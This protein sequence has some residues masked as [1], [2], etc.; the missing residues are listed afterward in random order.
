MELPIAL[1]R[2]G[3]LGAQVYR[4]LREAI[5]DGRLASGQALPATRALARRL[6]VSRNTVLGAYE[7]LCAEGFLTGRAGAGT[8]V[9]AGVGARKPRAPA[10]AELR[11]R[12]IW[13]TLVNPAPPAPPAPFDFR[14][15]SPIRGSSRGTAGG[16]SW[17]AS[18]AAGGQRSDIRRPRATRGSE[19]RWRGPS[20]PPAG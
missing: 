4:A 17:P 6:A 3:R 18:S 1:G 19:P 14:L 5:L 15:G 10:G 20:A 12:A 8:F 7:R 2:S 11:T 16:A 9:A 13:R